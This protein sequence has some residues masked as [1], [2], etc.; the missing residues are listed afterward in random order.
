MKQKQITIIGAGKLGKAV[1]SVIASSLVVD[2]WDKD[3]SKRTTQKTFEEVVSEADV[4]LFCIPSWC[5]RESAESVKK[6]MQPN[7]IGISFAKGLEQHTG[8]TS[9]EILEEVLGKK[10]A[11]IMSGPLFAHDLEGGKPGY[12]FF[13]SKDL[14]ARKLVKQ[15][16]QKTHIVVDTTDDTTGVALAGVLKN[17]YG[18]GIGMLDGIY[19]GDNK[20][21][22]YVTEAIQ[23][24]KQLGISLGGKKKTMD[25]SFVI[26]DFIGTCYCPFSNH[27]TTGEHIAKGEEGGICEGLISA[28]FI[29]KKSKKKLEILSK[30]ISV[31]L[32]NKSPKD[33]F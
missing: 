8:K 24:L 15:I 12:A 6:Y 10:R 13:G 11:G 5:M 19:A 3:E 21:A 31:F 26:A 29:A 30:I 22:K 25:H 28:P 1:E 2:S 9:Y 33:V 18:V 16:F 27:R 17:V 32:E 14:S 20:K 7:A 23:E 4:I